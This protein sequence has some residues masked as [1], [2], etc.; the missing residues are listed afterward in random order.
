[1]VPARE[2]GLLQLAA[3]VFWPYP[4]V[5]LEWPTPLI[6][7]KRVDR[8]LDGVVQPYIVVP[9]FSAIEYL[10]QESGSA[11]CPDRVPDPNEANAWTGPRVLYIVKRPFPLWGTKSL[12]VLVALVNFGNVVVVVF[13]D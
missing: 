7:C 3:P 11:E 6:D 2:P 10:S 8:V 5:G 13:L 12:V 4:Y 1:A 9:I